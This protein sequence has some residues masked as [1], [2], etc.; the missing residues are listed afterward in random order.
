MIEEVHH[1]H[2]VFRTKTPHVDQRMRMLVP[3]QDVLE[4]RTRGNK[5]HLVSLHLLAILTGQ[6]HI[7]KVVVLFQI[8][9]NSTL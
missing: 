8:S 4:E 9:K 7:S 2:Q 1:G 3:L 5:N 6:G